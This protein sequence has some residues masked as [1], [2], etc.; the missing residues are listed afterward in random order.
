MIKFNNIIHL[1]GIPQ[2]DPPPNP[3]APSAGPMNVAD[4]KPG[5]SMEHD[6]SAKWSYPFIE[7]T[8]RRDPDATLYP[9]AS[10]REGAA[11][12]QRRQEAA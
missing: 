2:S 6:L 7:Q 5:K 8:Q 12:T 11:T 10:P 1:K 4:I 9:P 3:R